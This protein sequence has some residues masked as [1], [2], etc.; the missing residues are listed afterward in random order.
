MHVF[1]KINSAAKYRLSPEPVNLTVH[2]GSA[3]VTV[4]LELTPVECVTYSVSVVPSTDVLFAQNSL[5][6]LTLSYNTSHSVNIHTTSYYG[7]YNSATTL[8]L[9]YGK[10]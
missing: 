2:L 10:L 4:T 6:N 7:Y 8:T 5:W 9:K 1:H 3:N